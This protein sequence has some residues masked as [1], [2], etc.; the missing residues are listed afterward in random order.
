MVVAEVRVELVI[1][2]LEMFNAVS[3]IAV[4]QKKELIEVFTVNSERHNLYLICVD[5]CPFISI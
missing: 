1:C 3:L 5:S 2:V 4:V